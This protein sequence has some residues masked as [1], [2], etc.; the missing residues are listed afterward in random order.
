VPHVR[1]GVRGPKMICI[2][3]FLQLIDSQK[4][5][6]G[7]ARLIRPT[8]AEANVGH[9]SSSYGV[10]LVQRLRRDSIVNRRPLSG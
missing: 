7:F 10:L 9:P 4:A 3:C 5:M 1:P 6:V 8:Y 2:D